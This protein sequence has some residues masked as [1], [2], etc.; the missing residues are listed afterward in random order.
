MFSIRNLYMFP[1]S[2]H[3]LYT[4]DMSYRKCETWNWLRTFMWQPVYSMYCKLPPNGHSQFFNVDST[5][6]WRRN[7]DVEKALK[8]IRIFRRSS[9]KH[10]NFDVFSTSVEIFL[11]FS[12]LFDV[13][14]NRRRNYPLGALCPYSNLDHPIV[15]NHFPCHWNEPKMISM[16]EILY[17]I[18]VLNSTKIANKLAMKQWMLHDIHSKWYV[19]CIFKYQCGIVP[20]YLHEWL[21]IQSPSRR[22]NKSQHLSMIHF[23]ITSRTFAFYIL[24]VRQVIT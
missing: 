21:W 13:D 22:D 5:S 17:F 11:R 12:T 6:N 24:T 20:I 15:V 1:L 23:L 7:L 16:S 9:K 3:V 19:I 10:R 4:C 14:S 2:I 18:I 8:N